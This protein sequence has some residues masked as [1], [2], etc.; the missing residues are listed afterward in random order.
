MVPLFLA[1]V[2]DRRSKWSC[3][4]ALEKDNITEVGFEL[5]G[6]FLWGAPPQMFCSQ[7]HQVRPPSRSFASIIAPGWSLPTSLKCFATQLRKWPFGMCGWKV[8]SLWGSSCTTTTSNSMSTSAAVLPSRRSCA[9]NAVGFVATGDTL[10]VKVVLTLPFQDELGLLSLL[11]DTTQAQ[12]RLRI[13]LDPC[14][15]L[16]CFHLWKSRVLKWIWCAPQAPFMI[17]TNSNEFCKGV[18][19]WLEWRTVRIILSTGCWLQFNSFLSACQDISKGTTQQ[20]QRWSER[21]FHA[22]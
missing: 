11:D 1:F 5:S 12:R 6:G 20:G 8:V 4:V 21:V 22:G 17:R 10:V 19:I 15:R 16:E 13:Y 3:S 18:K 14:F 7:N 2:Q 9:H